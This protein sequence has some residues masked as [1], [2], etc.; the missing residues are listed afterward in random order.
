MRQKTYQLCIRLTNENPD[1]GGKGRIKL[2]N[3]IKKEKKKNT[4]IQIR[5]NNGEVTID[6]AHFKSRKDTT[7][8][9]SMERDFKF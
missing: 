5:N 3:F 4:N 2:A 1:S 6:R 7:S 9:I 8:Y